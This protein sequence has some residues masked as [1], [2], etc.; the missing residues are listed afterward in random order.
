MARDDRGMPAGGQLTLVA[1]GSQNVQLS[2]NPEQTYFYKVFKR[3]THFSQESV[4]IP[5]EGPNELNMDYPTRIRAKIPRHGDLLTDLTFV[6]RVPE[7]YSK[8]YDQAVTPSFRWIHMLGPLLID[9]VSII[10]GGSKIQEFPG[11][12]IVARAT[13]DYPVDR[14][15]KWRSL[16]GDVPELHTPEWGVYGRSPNYPFAG[17]EYP[18]VVADPSGNPTSPSVPE[19][20]LRVPLPFWFSENWGRALPLISLQLHE[21]EV[22]ITMR[23]LGEI[24][25]IMESNTMAEPVRCGR[26][27]AIDPDK[28]VYMD[29][30]TLPLPLVPDNLTLQDDYYSSANC[31]YTPRSFFT[32]AG[33]PV[34]SQDGFDLR[35]RLEG[36][37]IYLTEAEQR[38]FAERDLTQAVHQ[39]QTFRFPSIVTRTKLDLDSHGIAHR[40]VFYGRRSDAIESRNDYINCSNWKDKS[41]APYWPLNAPTVTPNSGRL[42]DFAQHDILRSARLMLAGNEAFEEKPAAFFEAQ[43]AFSNMSGQGIPIGAAILRPDDVM[44]PIYQ[45]SFALN[46]SDHEQPSGTLNTSR[47]RE[48][49]LEVTPWTLDPQSNYVYDFTVFV[50]SINFVKYTSGMAGLQYAI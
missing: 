16:V 2:G 40:M 30:H 47:V 48:I 17:G 22:Q 14:Y 19:R 11:E 32:D 12:W 1:Y 37:F 46:G 5:M 29:P 24:Y 21:V 39:V 49:Q 6:F 45:I 44:G 43:T 28:P 38:M 42:I 10:V 3:Y 26:A 4:T 34:P 33:Q 27:L 23:S 15:L 31:G 36:T 50:E 20:E 25:R 8:V 9:N 35:P 41:K 13:V 7:M 18:H